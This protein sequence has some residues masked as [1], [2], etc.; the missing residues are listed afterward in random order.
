MK[1]ALTLIIV[2]AS[3]M[4]FAYEPAKGHKAEHKA[5][6]AEHKAKMAEHKDEIKQACSNDVAKAGCSDKEMGSGLLKC[7]QAYKK[8]NKDFEISESCKNATKSLRDERKEW[9]AKK[10]AEKAEKAEE[11]ADK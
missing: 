11:K 10:A 4:A 6:M 3:G 7:L 5:K 1:L 2:A 8:E 9:K